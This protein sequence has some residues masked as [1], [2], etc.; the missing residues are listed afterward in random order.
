MLRDRIQQKT[1]KFQELEKTALEN[2]QKLYGDSYKPRTI[3][4]VKSS[5]K[6]QVPDLTVTVF[7]EVKYMNITSF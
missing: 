4:A 7:N 5:D 3:V 2:G 1:A 6:K